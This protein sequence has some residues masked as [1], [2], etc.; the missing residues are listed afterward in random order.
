MTI[1]RLSSLLVLT[2]VLT[3]SATLHA[4]PTATQQCEATVEKATG[5]YGAC[6]LKAESIFAL[7]GDTAKRDQALLKCSTVLDAAF[8][9]AILKWGVAACTTTPSSA[10]DG[11]LAACSDTTVTVARGG[12]FPDCGD[13]SV[14]TPDEQCDG[15]DLGGTTCASLGH[16]G[17]SLGCSPACRFDT[18]ACDGDGFPASGQTS[19]WSITGTP[20]DCAGTGQD[21]EQK[22]GAALAYVDGG[23]GTVTD[24]NTGLQWE[25]LDDANGLHDW[26]TD[27]DWA[28]AF[29]KVAALNAA[30]FAGHT[31]WR[32]P[33]LK[34]LHSL[35]DF[36]RFEVA[37]APAFDNA[38][39]SGCSSMTCSCTRDFNY[40]WSSSTRPDLTM[41]A[42]V[43]GAREGD[44]NHQVK[45]SRWPVRA[46]RGGL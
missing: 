2:A 45:S 14:N 39:S 38:C 4:A 25:K 6:R 42:Y 18:S 1:I 22:A 28:Q 17:G 27:Y 16:A 3:A 40:Y 37:L 36:G 34:E 41:T 20:I 21:G 8:G 33:N 43:V 13:G 15:G 7:V 44:V 46:V 26:D 32:L 12:A 24:V 23:D 10:F 5:R 11:H 9:K 19:C 31:D 30:A 35:I 29:A